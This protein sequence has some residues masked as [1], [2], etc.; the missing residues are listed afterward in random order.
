MGHPTCH[1]PIRFTAVC[2]LLVWEGVGHL[3]GRDC[4]RGGCQ[5]VLPWDTPCHPLLPRSSEAS[6]HRTRSLE[7]PCRDLNCSVIGLILILWVWVIRLPVNW[8]KVTSLHL[9]LIGIFN[10]K[11]CLMIA[12]EKTSLPVIKTLT[13]FLQEEKSKLD[14]QL[15]NNNHHSPLSSC[16]Q[17]PFSSF[18]GTTNTKPHP[19]HHLTWPLFCYCRLKSFMESFDRY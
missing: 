1:Q 16:E 7:E 11:R 4:W 2:R 5:A 10:Q 13:V 17:V 18:C 14:V 6:S 19:S 15:N 9:A 8:R 12:S 3:Q